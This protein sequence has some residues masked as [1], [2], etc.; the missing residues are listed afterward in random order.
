MRQLYLTAVRQRVGEDDR[1]LAAELTN[2][3]DS[4]ARWC[5]AWLLSDNLRPA[6]IN[7]MRVEPSKENL[8][9]MALATTG[10]LRDVRY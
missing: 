10:A 2:S 9:A 6:I 5:A 1:A 3:G 4:G 8:R 7:A